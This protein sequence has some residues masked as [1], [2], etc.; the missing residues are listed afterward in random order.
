M[1]ELLFVIGKTYSWESECNDWCGGYGKKTVE[2]C[3]EMWGALPL[4]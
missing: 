2:E 1:E 4:P 3:V